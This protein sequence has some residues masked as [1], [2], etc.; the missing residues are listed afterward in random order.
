MTR[1]EQRGLYSGF[2]AGRGKESN[3]FVGFCWY[4]IGI[5]DVQE[6]TSGLRRGMTSGARV[7]WVAEKKKKRKGKRRG[8]H[9]LAAGL[10]RC[11]LVRGARAGTAWPN[12][13]GSVRLVQLCF[14]ENCFF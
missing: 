4:P 13:P 7:A 1:G 10:G 14:S 5:K 2:G 6:K 3:K 8:G 9:G 12:L 11:R